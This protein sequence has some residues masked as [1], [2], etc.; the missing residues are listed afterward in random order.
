M[1]YELIN[2]F[3]NEIIKLEK[4]PFI[5]IYLPTHREKPDSMQD[6]TRLK[7]LIKE[8]EKTLK[9]EY[10]DANSEAILKP[11]K[12]IEGDNLFWNQS[13]EGL[14]ILANEDKCIV[15]RLPQT[16]DEL[17]VVADSFHIKPLIR[18]YQS[19]DRYNI[20]T[21]NRTSFKLY[22]GDRYGFEEVKIDESIPT[23]L[24]DVLGTDFTK[25]NLASGRGP[26]TGLHGLEDKQGEVDKDTEKYFRYVDKFVTENYSN[27]TK[28]P[29]ILVTLSEHQGIFRG[30]TNNSHLLKEAIN[31]DPEALNKEQLKKHVWETLE[32]LYIEKTKKL[33]DKFENARAQFKGSDDV[34]EI[35]RA[36]TEG[37]IGTLLI[38]AGR[39]IKGEILEDGKLKLNADSD[40]TNE[41]V[42]DDISE[43]VFRDGGEV[44][45]LPKERMPSTTGAAAIF[46]Y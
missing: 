44:I 3:P 38:E 19:A 20:L 1:S 39:I 43:A 27:P 26:G 2:D 7:N 45:V 37:K 11:I 31:I 18:V 32:P 14:A 25:N 28:L 24:E 13:K 21:L 15:Y 12:E 6:A 23:S 36:S 5:S 40:N 10:K 46:R 22:Q 16:V 9:E 42:L 30:I 29:L 35:G 34:A 17:A 33:V 41:D 4:G 8:V